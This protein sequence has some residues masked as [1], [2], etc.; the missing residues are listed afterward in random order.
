MYPQMAID[1]KINLSYNVYLFRH[2]LQML[3]TTGQLMISAW[4]ELVTYGPLLQVSMY[5][6]QMMRRLLGCNLMFFYK[7]PDGP[8]YCISRK[9]NALND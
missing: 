7:C 4:M 8:N 9:K 6:L 2:T 1:S 5:Y 3:N